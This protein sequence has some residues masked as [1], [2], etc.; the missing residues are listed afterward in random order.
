MSGAVTVTSIRHRVLQ[1]DA[2]LARGG[3]KG[4]SMNIAIIT[5]LVPTSGGGVEPLTVLLSEIVMDAR[6]AVK[7]FDPFILNNEYKDFLNMKLL[8]FYKLA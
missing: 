1:V 5:P 4:T 8:G 3:I 7:R 2:Q 6:H